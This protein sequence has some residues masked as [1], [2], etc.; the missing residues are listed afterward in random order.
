MSGTAVD[1]RLYFGATKGW[2]VFDE[3]LLADARSSEQRVWKWDVTS[4]TER[5]SSLSL[6]ESNLTVSKKLPVEVS[7]I[8]VSF[9]PGIVKH[10]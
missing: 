7:L 6:S 4:E 9:F 10:E 1:R 8:K 2:L 5:C 3:L